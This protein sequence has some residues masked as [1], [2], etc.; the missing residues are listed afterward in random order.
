[1][2]FSILFIGYSL[3]NMKILKKIYYGIIFHLRYAFLRNE[4]VN[5]KL[6][7]LL[8]YLNEIG[9]RSISM[10][11]HWCTIVFK[12]NTTIEFWNANRWYGWMSQG[13]ISFSNGKVLEWNDTMPSNEVLVKFIK[14]VT[15]LDKKQQ[16]EDFTQYLP[17]K[18]L[19]K[20]KLKKL[21]SL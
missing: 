4:D 10:D 2:E 20:A 13:K 6:D 19:R 3:Y 7:V 16:K 1:M 15:F 12:D 18:V 21:N 9:I 14:I 8:V 11:Y 5:R 17:V